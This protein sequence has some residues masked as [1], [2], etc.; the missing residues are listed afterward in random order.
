MRKKILLYGIGTFKNRGVEAII[1]STLSMI[2]SKKYNVTLATY[3][4]DYNKEKYKDIAKVK[5]YYKSEELTEEEQKKEQEYKNLPFDYHNFEK[6]YQKDVIKAIDDSDIC[7]SV[8]GDNYCYPYCNWL[9]TLD[10]YAHQKRKRTILWGASLFD[11]ITDDDLINDLDKFDI[12]VIRESLSYNA[13]KKYIPENKL[14]YAPDPAFSMLPQKV[15]LNAW[16]RGRKIVAINVSPLTVQNEG[17]KQAIYDLIEYLLK[18]TKYS[19]LLLPHVTTE[20]CNDLDI[21]QKLKDKYKQEDRIYLEL[22][23]YNCQQLKYIISK[24]KLLVAARTHASIA[25]YSTGVPT[26]VIGYSVKS[27]GL[28][29]DLFGNFKNY[30]ISKDELN[31]QN[32]INSFRYIDENQEKIRKTLNEKIPKIKETS[33]NLFNLVLDKIKEQEEQ[34]ICKRDSCIGCSV[35]ASKCP[36]NAITMVENDEGF[37]YPKIDLKK[38]THCNICRNN[39]PINKQAQKENQFKK[40]CYA[41]I[42]LNTEEQLKSTSGGM[43][44][45]LAHAILNMNGVVYGSCMKGTKAE[46][47]RV[48]KEKE[49]DEIR[50]SKYIQSSII[51]IYDKLKKDLNSNKPV[52]FCGTPLQIGAIK[53]FLGKD[54]DN[55]LLVSLLCHGVMSQ[56][57]F[58]KYIKELEEDRNTQVEK[59]K[60]RTKN[61]KWTTASIEYKA[62]DNNTQVEK[63]IDNDLMK[64]YLKNYIL[65][66]SCYDCQFRRDNNEADIILGDFWGIEV[67]DREMLDEKGVSALVIN[68]AKGKE[69]INKNEIFSK[70]KSKKENINDMIKYNPVLI[71]SVIKPKD[72]KKALNDLKNNS[73]KLVSQYYYNYQE[74]NNKEKELAQKVTQIKVE[75]ERLYRKLNSILNS[76]RW[77][78]MDKGINKI[79]KIL[80]R[81]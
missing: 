29:K 51:N 5:H 33:L 24:C 15:N 36:H 10:E 46:H 59:F 3:D 58:E 72:R 54:Y 47:I 78:L 52:L 9:Y 75:N 20:D 61:N 41:A 67:I 39:C 44:S 77:K 56:T 37:I 31:S 35:C 13:V 14:I 42:N 7:I 74:L 80:G 62:M 43:F 73:I 68:S 30:V 63:F 45:I 17:Q 76:K 25:A 27:R 71:K 6:L 18:E 34:E 11:E 50:G 38:C 4:F 55:L 69:F 60:F 48:T 28:A 8:G 1:N 40:E 53:T 57:I 64:L 70:I 66:E 23:N 49:L 2:D 79:N 81:K 32:L 12:L 26:L 65:R 16:Y 21:L 19:V 22:E